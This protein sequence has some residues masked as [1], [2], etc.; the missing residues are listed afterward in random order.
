MNII[1]VQAQCYLTQKTLFPLKIFAIQSENNFYVSKWS[2]STKNKT[3]Y[4][5]NLSRI[6]FWKN[7]FTLWRSRK[8][9]QFPFRKKEP[10]GVSENKCKP[11]GILNKNCRCQ[12]QMHGFLIR[13][14]LDK[15][16]T[17]TRKLTKTFKFEASNNY[18]KNITQF[19]TKILTVI[20]FKINPYPL[21]LCLRKKLTRRITKKRNIKKKA[22]EERGQL[23]LKIWKT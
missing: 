19:V 14:L 7:D 23:F 18:C 12:E 2:N 10:K 8:E 16:E 5:S 6:F 9:E 15:Q 1:P 4:L 21:R 11:A 20:S 17:R 3:L 13:H 22:K